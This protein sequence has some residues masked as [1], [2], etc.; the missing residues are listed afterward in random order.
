MTNSFF[1]NYKLEN[2]ARF[3]IK[4]EFYSDSVSFL[5]KGRYFSSGENMMM[6]CD[7]LWYEIFLFERSLAIYGHVKCS[8]W[9]SEFYYL[10]VI[11][12]FYCIFCYYKSKVTSQ[13]LFMGM[14]CKRTS[15]TKLEKNID[16]PLLLWNVKTNKFRHNTHWGV[17]KKPFGLILKKRGG[18]GDESKMYMILW[19][20]LSF[21][22]FYLTPFNDQ[23]VPVHHCFQTSI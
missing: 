19:S 8:I 5:L 17:W 21:F 22:P 16:L 6:K 11:I 3:Q 15:Q 18:R 20:T 7:F 23:K 4:S 9:F 12:S 2:K 13:I 1:F 14:C 10:A